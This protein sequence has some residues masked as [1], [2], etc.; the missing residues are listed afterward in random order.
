MLFTQTRGNVYL[1]MSIVQVLNKWYEYVVSIYPYFYFIFQSK[2]HYI[3]LVVHHCVHV[4]DQVHEAAELPEGVH[5]DHGHDEAVLQGSR[6]IHGGVH[7]RIL[8]IQR[9]LLL[10]PQELPGELQGLH[11][12]RGEHSELLFHY[13]FG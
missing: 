4:Y 10:R 6:H 9:L 13:S 3:V 1:R 12:D 7:H 5:A 8:R 2:F 11:Q